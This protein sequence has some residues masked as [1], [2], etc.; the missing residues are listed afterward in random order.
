MIQL[1]SSPYQLTSRGLRPD[2]HLYEVQQEEAGDGADGDGQRVDGGHHQHNALTYFYQ[3]VNLKR[4]VSMIIISDRVPG[5]LIEYFKNGL[6]YDEKLSPRLTKDAAILL[7][8]NPHLLSFT[9]EQPFLVIP[10]QPLEH[11]GKLHKKKKEEKN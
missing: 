4:H 10:N 5:N 8:R 7:G 3:T 2:E 1:N 6:L 11:K 9:K